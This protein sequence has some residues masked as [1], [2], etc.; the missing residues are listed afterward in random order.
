LPNCQAGRCTVGSYDQTKSATFVAGTEAFDFEYQGSTIVSGQYFG[1]TVV[2]AGVS[3]LDFP[4]GLATNGTHGGNQGY[5]I[6]Y[7]VVGVAINGALA[8]VPQ[9]QGPYANIVHQMVVQN[10]IS[11]R[12]FSLWLN[13]IR[14]Q[15]GQKQNSIQKLTCSRLFHW[16][17]PLW[18]YRYCQIHWKSGRLA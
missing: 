4:I 6:T 11:G 14:K 2:V 9:G 1:D 10:V 12:A 17:N 18:W 8:G 3:M 5:D 16:F 13:D 7:G 15:L